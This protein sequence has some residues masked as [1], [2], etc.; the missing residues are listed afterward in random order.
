MKTSPETTEQETASVKSK[1]EGHLSPDG[2]WRTFP[3]VPNLMQYVA[4]GLYFGRVKV[5]GKSF[6]ESLETNVFSTA[7]LPFPDYVKAKLKQSKHQTV[8]TFAE[9]GLLYQEQTNGDHAI[10]ETSKIYRCK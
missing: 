5:N 6:R 8:S 7:K 10:K 1:R 4:T 9:A 2:K 3:K